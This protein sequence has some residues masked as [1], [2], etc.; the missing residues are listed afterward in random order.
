MGTAG[1]GNFDNDA[2][3]CWL[4]DLVEENLIRPIDESIRNFDEAEAEWLMGA[5]EVLCSLGEQFASPV[6][7][8]EK[9]KA[10]RASYVRGWNTVIDSLRPVP[11]FKNERLAVIEQTFDRLERLSVENNR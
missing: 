9:V 8:V 2:A 1:A 10:W 7:D 4:V 11:G 5:V 6:P 3:Y